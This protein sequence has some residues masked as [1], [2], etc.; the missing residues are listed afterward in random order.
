MKKSNF[1]LKILNTLSPVKHALKETD[2][3]SKPPVIIGQIHTS[4][5]KQKI[6]E[7]EKDK[8]QSK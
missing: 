4:K 1:L 2:K 7:K 3:L 5:I 8:R 6:K